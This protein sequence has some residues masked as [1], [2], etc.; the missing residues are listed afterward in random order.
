ML[1]KQTKVQSIYNI[2]ISNY[3]NTTNIRVN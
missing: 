2:R 3:C 1:Y